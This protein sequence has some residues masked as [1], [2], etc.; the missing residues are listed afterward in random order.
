MSYDSGMACIRQLPAVFLILLVMIVVP[1]N[2]HS[3]ESFN[4]GQFE[5]AYG[6]ADVES[7]VRRP[8]NPP[9]PHIS[10]AIETPEPAVERLLNQ[11]QPNN[12]T[13]KQT[14]A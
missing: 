6:L 9:L 4:P 13:F 11:G 5:D 14:S 8:G 10:E 12:G 1:A 2:D 7:S 3:T